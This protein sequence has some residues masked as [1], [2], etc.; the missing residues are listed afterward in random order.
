M[1]TDA[2]DQTITGWIKGLDHYTL[3]ELRSKPSLTSWS[4]GQVYFHLIDNTWYYIEE[5]KT[6]LSSDDHSHEQAL[7]G[8]AAMLTNNEFPDTL[9]EGPDTNTDIPQPYSKEELKNA[10]SQIKNEISS[11]AIL[12]SNSHHKG[13]TNHPGLGYFSAH[14]WLQFADMHFRHHLRQKK[15]IDEFLRK[16]N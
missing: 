9:I 7:P 11:L 1:T 12:I 6:C 14:D 8:G 15:R 10:L 3:G 4:L 13:K 16:S 5:A 2:F